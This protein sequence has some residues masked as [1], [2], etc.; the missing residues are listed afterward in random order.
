MHRMVHLQEQAVDIGSPSQVG[1]LALGP[2][3]PGQLMI[4]QAG[5]PDRIDLQHAEAG[6]CRRC[7]VARQQRTGQQQRTGKET[8][9]VRP[10]DD[11]HGGAG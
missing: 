10:G 8:G 6:E 11:S 7:L 4:A 3:E 9:E 2:G 1:C 5:P